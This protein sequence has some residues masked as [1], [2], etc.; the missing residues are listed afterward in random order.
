[1]GF[2]PQE[3][4]TFLYKILMGRISLITEIEKRVCYRIMC[5][6]EEV[7]CLVV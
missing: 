2:G 4:F 7:N 5:G 1:M 6:Y 3:I